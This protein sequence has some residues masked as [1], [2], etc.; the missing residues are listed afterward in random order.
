MITAKLTKRPVLKAVVTK[1]YQ[2]KGYAEGYADGKQDGK[3]EA[4][5]EIL[6]TN[7]G[8]MYK[9]H[10]IISAEGVD[11]I[12]NNAY[13]NANKME[14]LEV[15]NIRSIWSAFSNVFQNCTALKSVKLPKILR[16]GANYFIGCT[17]LEEVV[18]GCEE[19]PMEYISSNVFN[20][21]SAL[22]R[23]RYIG[24]ISAS[25]SF[26]NSPLLDDE[27]IQGIVDAL[28]EVATAQTL[29]LHNT[30]G[31]KLT[32]AQKATITAKKW[33]LVY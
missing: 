13:Q 20:G 11:G 3:D 22:V 2:G 27:S 15:P 26:A 10:Y 7:Y 9:K 5:A 30:V 21:C 33:T 8:I 14:T 23:F 16:I 25:L 19:Y 6:W 31:N 29:T 18:L 28:A 32:D 24:T 12:R 4:E 17:A 1:P